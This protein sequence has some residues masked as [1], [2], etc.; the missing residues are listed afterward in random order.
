V[1]FLNKIEGALKNT[2]LDADA[3]RPLPVQHHQFIF[4]QALSG[5]FP[6]W[7]VST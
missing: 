5:V 3:S 6:S 2:I 7:T 4:S 1:S